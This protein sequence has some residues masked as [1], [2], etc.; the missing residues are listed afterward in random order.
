MRRENAYCNTVSKGLV[1]ST[2][3]SANTEIKG[4]TEVVIYVSL[5]ADVK[6][7]ILPDFSGKTEAEAAKLIKELGLQ[8]GSVTYKASYLPVGTVLAQSAM[9]GDEI[10]VGTVIDF[11][12]S[13]GADYKP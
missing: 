13:G 5:G 4:D 2:F 3:P 12:V 1:C 6:A 9:A 8:V 10:P 11:N 7:V